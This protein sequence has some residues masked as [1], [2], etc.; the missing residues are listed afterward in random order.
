M[1]T[2]AGRRRAMMCPHMMAVFIKELLGSCGLAADDGDVAAF[3]ARS[4]RL[5][6][7]SQLLEELPAMSWARS[8]RTLAQAYEDLLAQRDNV[9]ET[10]N[11]LHLLLRRALLQLEN[12][13]PK[14]AASLKSAGLES[15]SRSLARQLR[16]GQGARS[17]AELMDQAK[18]CMPQS[19]RGTLDSAQGSDDETA[20]PEEDEEP[21]E[22]LRSNSALSEGRRSDAPFAEDATVGMSEPL[23]QEGYQN[24]QS[25]LSENAMAA[26]VRKLLVEQ[27]GE[28]LSQEGLVEF[29]RGCLDD[30]TP[31]PR[32]QEEL[33]QGPKW[34]GFRKTGRGKLFVDRWFDG[35]SKVFSARE[36]RHHLMAAS[37]ERSSA[38]FDCWDLDLQLAGAHICFVFQAKPHSLGTGGE[39]DARNGDEEFFGVTV[40]HIQLRKKSS[41]RRVQF[42]VHHFQIDNMREVD[43]VRPIIICPEDSG[44]YSDRR[45][46]H[47]K[48]R[49]DKH[50]TEADTIPF[51]YFCMEKLPSGILH[52]K[53]LELLL[54]PVIMRLDVGFWIQIV[55]Q[56]MEWANVGNSSAAE[57]AGTSEEDR[58]IV[59]KQVLSMREGGIDLPASTTTLRPIY[60]EWFRLGALI[61]QVE[62]LMPMKMKILMQGKA[63]SGSDSASST[64]EDTDDQQD[65]QWQSLW[66]ARILARL[67]HR[68]HGYMKQV[69]MVAQKGL[70]FVITSVGSGVLSGVGHITPR[71]SFPETVFQRTFQDL[72]P[73]AE[74]LV[75]DYV[76]TGMY[77]FW[78]VLFSINLLGDPI[79]LGTSVAGGVVQ[80]FRKTGSEVIAGDLKGEGLLSLA[81]GVLGGTAAT[82]GKFFG[83][84]GDTIDALAQTGDQNPNFQLSTVNHVG[85]GITAGAQVFI[86]NTASGIAGLV[87]APVQ[88][89]QR[90]G[91]VGLGQ[92]LLKGMR[93]VVAKPVSGL[94]HGVQHIAEGVDATTRLWDHWEQI[95]PRRASRPLPKGSKLL[96]LVGAEFSPRITVYVESLQFLNLESFTGVSAALSQRL[97]GATY[98]VELSTV[99]T[100]TWA[101]A[102]KLGRLAKDGS[103]V[104]NEVKWVPT[105]TL[106]ES[107]ILIE[108]QDCALSG[109]PTRPKPVY[110]AV[111]P[112]APHGSSVLQQVA[113]LMREP[114]E[115]ATLDGFTCRIRPSQPF[116]VSLN[117]I[118]GASPAELLLRFWPAWDPERVPMTQRWVPKTINSPTGEHL[119]P[120]QRKEGALE[121]RSKGAFHHWSLKWVV[122]DNHQF[123][124]W[125]DRK[126]FEDGR[127]PKVRYHLS[128]PKCIY[129]FAAGEAPEACFAQV[130][131]D[132]LLE[133]Q[134]RPAHN[135]RETSGNWLQAVLRHTL[136]E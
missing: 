92:G 91:V 84:L 6:A 18:Q 29:A 19:R 75:R 49:K 24:V 69:F 106:M 123:T 16:S 61:A 85:D 66:L 127:Q 113:K 89:F 55:Q 124:Y 129:R 116:R 5:P 38:H 39:L 63:A 13:Q 100:G 117:S 80:F 90:K 46:R 114:K 120:P 40:D 60:L 93:G 95:V 17:W 132:G 47:H 25:L 58:E 83:A 7:L 110:R 73:F 94:M 48:K 54:Q 68:S 27:G 65:A 10:A 111:L 71:F 14:L 99:S 31:F 79:G 126:D 4:S 97:R 119:P 42:F 59:A 87:Q 118:D 98:R 32:V 62:I 135:E 133:A 77:Q 15:L 107:D 56:L 108:V 134:W 136:Q 21:A 130:R 67:T 109:D 43:R 33:L 101:K 26:F 86:H 53:E 41:Q 23:T 96:P 57:A 51:V 3:V 12:E 44:Y 34:A 45:E 22:L 37:T 122:L 103:V 36:S 1:L 128:D 8:V 74:S 30:S 88:G 28:V 81:Q 50:S 78:K 70:V 72:T 121:K 105:Q 35:V 104:F 9:D 112:R 102:S 52:F 115:L 76:K 82:A 64:L 125:N 11:V 20:L 131:A 2:E